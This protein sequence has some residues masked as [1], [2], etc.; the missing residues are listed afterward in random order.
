[1]IPQ[2]KITLIRPNEDDS[3]ALSFVG[4]TWHMRYSE[5]SKVR[6]LSL[7]TDDY[8]R[9]KK[10]RD[11]HY[12]IMTGNGAVMRAKIGRKSIKEV[13]RNNPDSNL[14]IYSQEPYIVRVNGKVIIETDD[15]EKAKAARNK[16]VEEMR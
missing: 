15:Y 14:G 3:H 9:A 16:F 11:S 5:G 8:T 13:I 1:M 10:L 12:A 2:S 7:K 4:N 6:R